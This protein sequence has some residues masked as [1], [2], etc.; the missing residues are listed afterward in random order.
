MDRYPCCEHCE[1]EC[2]AD[3]HAAPCPYGCDDDPD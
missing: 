1:P 3:D 2:P